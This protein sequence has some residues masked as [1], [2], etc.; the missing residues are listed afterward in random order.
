VGKL[1]PVCSVACG[2]FY[3]AVALEPYTGPSAVQMQKKHREKAEKKEAVARAKRERD[4]LNE[5]EEKRRRD[6]RRRDL[7]GVLNGSY[8]GCKACA[9]PLSCAGFVADAVRPT[10]CVL[11]G[12][13]RDSHGLLRRFADEALTN[14]MLED[15]VETAKFTEARFKPPTS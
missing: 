4:G 13:E 12:H 15:F 6:A 9:S 5:L 7:L 1:G 10:A 3:T 11:C 2:R 8:P 14:E